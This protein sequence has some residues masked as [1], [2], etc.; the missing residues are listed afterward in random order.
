M[1]PPFTGGVQVT[2]TVVS[3]PVA[4]TLVGAPGFEAVVIGAV[5]AE[6]SEEPM[7]FTATTVKA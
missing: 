1:P 4:T 5:A 2:L 6:G 7:A 3:P